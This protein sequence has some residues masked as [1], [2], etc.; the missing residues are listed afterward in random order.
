LG[1]GKFQPQALNPKLEKIRASSYKTFTVMNRLV[2]IIGAMVLLIANAAWA[3]E[4]CQSL[5]AHHAA[6]EHGEAAS[7]DHGPPLDSFRS[8]S[9]AEDQTIHCANSREVASFLS[10]PSPWIARSIGAYKTLPS[11]FVPFV[12]ESNGWIAYSEK[13]PPGSFLAAVSLYLSLSVLRV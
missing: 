3:L 6:H 13:R 12:A 4:R 2:G 5:N 10:Q 9:S 1:C 8:Q 11:P 7:L